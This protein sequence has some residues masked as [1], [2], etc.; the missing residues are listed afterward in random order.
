MPIE[1]VEV[2][3][4]I[5][6]KGLRLVLTT[7][8]PGPWGESA[9]GILKVKSL[10]YV[11]VRQTAG[12]VDPELMAWTRQ[13]SAPVAMYDSER[14]RSGWA[15][16]LL[17]AERVAPEPA[18]VPHDPRERAHMLGL[19]HEICGEQGLGWSRRLQ[20]F[21]GMPTGE[22]E[23]MPWKYGLEDTTAVENAAARTSA[24]IGLLAGERERSGG[25]YLL[26]EELRAVDIYWA[27]FSNLIEP[28][29][30]EASP[31]PDFIRGAYSSWAGDC[32]SSLIDLRNQVFERH[33]GLPQEY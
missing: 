14:P 11:A 19:C 17:L 15:E 8:V 10:D 25:P 18:L 30:P 12:N 23:S 5:E 28:L 1:Y 31:M 16:I 21:A 24:I 4:A 13:S 20:L 3:D 26:G 27:C 7:G 32:P 9:K 29:P 33:L 22:P 6:H 2:A